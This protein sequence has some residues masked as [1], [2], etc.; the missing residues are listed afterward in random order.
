MKSWIVSSTFFRGLIYSLRVGGGG[1]SLRARGCGISS[2]RVVGGGA[3]PLRVGWGDPHC[4]SVVQ[5]GS[6]L[7]WGRDHHCGSVG[8][9]VIA[10]Q[11]G[12]GG[13][14]LQGG[15]NGETNDAVIYRQ[16]NFRN[17]VFVVTADGGR[18]FGSEPPALF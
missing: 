16:S 2:L 11:L 14:S 1:S 5:G 13:S 10:R 12:R 4:G 8:G 18:G 15:E 7:R 17:N 9:I 3:S 6:S